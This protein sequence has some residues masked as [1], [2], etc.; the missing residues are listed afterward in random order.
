M[1]HQSFDL[2]P[3]RSHLPQVVVELMLPDVEKE[4]KMI[5]E[6]SGKT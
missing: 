6:R 3:I 4:R 1:N 5:M 2:I